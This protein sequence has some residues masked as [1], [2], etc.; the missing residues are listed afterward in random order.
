MVKEKKIVF[1]TDRYFEDQDLLQ[2]L[3]NR[4]CAKT[5]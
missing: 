5:G 1:Y 2:A 4:G 3:R